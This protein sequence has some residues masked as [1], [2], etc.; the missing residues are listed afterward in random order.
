MGRILVGPHAIE[1]YLGRMWER[2]DNAERT[3]RGREVDGGQVQQGDHRDRLRH[4]EPAD[5]AAAGLTF[6]LRAPDPSS[7]RPPGHAPRRSDPAGHDW[8]S[9]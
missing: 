6:T 4:P 2:Y 1:E 8:H 5:A 9:W 7:D 3:A